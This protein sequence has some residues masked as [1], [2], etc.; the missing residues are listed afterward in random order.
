MKAQIIF[1]SILFIAACGYDHEAP[2]QDFGSDQNYSDVGKDLN[3]DT[4]TDGILDMGNDGASDMGRDGASDMSRPSKKV[5]LERTNQNLKICS[6]MTPIKTLKKGT[7]LI[8]NPQLSFFNSKRILAYTEQKSAFSSD[9]ELKF[10]ELNVNDE[11]K[12][13]LIVSASQYYNSQLR[14]HKMVKNRVGVFQNNGKNLYSVVIKEN[15]DIQKKIKITTSDQEIYSFQTVSAHNKI[16]VLWKKRKGKTYLLILRDD[17]T[18][19]HKNRELF[20]VNKY[21]AW[22]HKIVERED[23]FG[24]VWLASIA[25]KKFEMVFLNLDKEGLDKGAP[26]KIY[27]SKQKLGE[28]YAFSDSLDLLATSKGYVVTWNEQEEVEGHLNSKIMIAKIN[29]RGI[30]MGDISVLNKTKDDIDFMSPNLVEFEG[31]IALFW[32]KGTFIYICAGCMPDHRVS[33]ILLDVEKFEPISTVLDISVQ[34]SSLGGLRNMQ[35]LVENTKLS[36]V[37]DAYYHVH[38]ESVF[39]K[40]ECK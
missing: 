38:E 28:S 17:G 39:G 27:T 26:T 10:S 21:G 29:K 8:S 40:I 1:F 30:S 19:L 7:K 32:A 3:S 31:N 24:I 36:I 22:P 16:A 13:D 15:G 33:M 34:Q 12:N 18:V 23:G 4:K 5:I 37:A 9:S 2:L 11:I 25:D 14:V 6:T 35:V 20:G